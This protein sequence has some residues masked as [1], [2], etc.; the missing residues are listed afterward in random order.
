MEE[1]TT[2]TELDFENMFAD[3]DTGDTNPTQ[4]AN[5]T[6]APEQTVTADSEPTAQEEPRYKV[7]YNGEEKELPLSELIV[8]AQK[9][10][11]YDKVVSKRDELA[12]EAQA[13]ERLAKENGMT[14][15]GYLQFLQTQ[16]EAQFVQE[17]S[18]E[19]I[20]ENA[21]KELFQLKQ[22]NSRLTEQQ[23]ELQE[24]E[25]Q[26]EQESKLKQQFVELYDHYP[27]LKELPQEAIDAIAA[28]KSP[29]DAYNACLVKELEA[30]LKAAEQNQ[31]NKQAAIGSVASDMV[32]DS[33]TDAFL[34]GF[35]G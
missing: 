5:E 27:D 29:L 1:N 7:K 33:E 2:L 28:G 3:E 30:K 6:P 10:M 24:K 19:G 21:A 34:Q 32:D 12:K 22:Q 26:K 20:P 9:G 8:N 16:R 4:E 18:V 14:R 25:R 11:N 13:L 31:K 35:L 17:K 15:E 23:K